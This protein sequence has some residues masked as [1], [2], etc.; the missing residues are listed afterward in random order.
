[1]ADILEIT[2]AFERVRADAALLR[3]FVQGTETES[4]TLGGV[5]TPSLRACARDIVESAQDAANRALGEL[6]TFETERGVLRGEVAAALAAAETAT[7]ASR[8]ELITHDG[9]TPARL[10]YG[11]PGLYLRG[12][13]NGMP[14]WS[15]ADS[16]PGCRAAALPVVTGAGTPSD[17]SV[18]LNEKGEVQAWGR[19]S[20]YANGSVSASHVHT[21]MLVGINGPRPEGG[22]VRLHQG[23][24]SAYALDAAGNVWSFG[25]NL[26]GEL[27]HGNTSARA[28]LTRIE[29]FAEHGIRIREVVTQQCYYPD[30]Y[31]HYT[32]V[33]FID[34]AGRLWGCGYNS[35]RELG[36]GDTAHKSTPARV[37]MLSG[38]IRAALGM[39]AYGSAYAITDDGRLWAW[40][41]NSTGE[42]GLGDTTPRAVPQLV[43][44][45]R[46]VTDVAASGYFALVRTED[47][48]VWG[49]GYNGAGQLGLGDTTQRTTWTRSDVVGAERVFAVD[50]HSYGSS[51]VI[52]RDG[53]LLCAGANAHG[54][55]GMG[56]T[57][58][59]TSFVKPAGDFQGRVSKVGAS[60]CNYSSTIVLD[61]AG[62]LWGAGYNG[63]GQLARGT[64]ACAGT[65]SA[66][67]IMAHGLGDGVRIVDMVV[68]GRGSGRHVIALTDDGRLLTCGYNGWGQLGTH[69]GN[70]ASSQDLLCVVRL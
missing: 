10:P 12:N 48:S 23:H 28:C 31:G 42:L 58:A 51:C 49:T 64:G 65:N 15:R 69:A 3:A 8:G 52:T 20:D 41:H 39:S 53:E 57:A 4:V 55:L 37:G 1:M 22:F 38:V 13:K 54:Q 27:G 32:S 19:G 5:E 61:A 40:G 66:F 67:Q 47:G 44:A 46:D 17:I 30:D 50:Y 59:K 56:D 18:C 70:L 68:A 24:N 26:Y 11:A 21:P 9:T 7:P 14:A 25:R 45:V 34:D 2:K 36:T 29:Y 35:Y 43:D 6:A 63:Y 62:R 16:R 33:L 60:C